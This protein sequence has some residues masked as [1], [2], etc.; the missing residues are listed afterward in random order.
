MSNKIKLAYFGTPIFSVEL[1]KKII[2]EGRDT[3]EV[4]CAITQPDK[5]VGRDQKITACPVKLF[6]LENSIA[7]F[8]KINDDV[9]E[10]LKSC[11]IALVF[12]F[13]HILNS[14]LLRA[15]K[16]GFWNVH[17]SA[18]P[19]YRGPSPIAFPMLLGDSESAISLIQ[20]DEKMDHG[21][22]IAQ[23]KTDIPLDI[24]HNELLTKMAQMSYYILFESVKKIATN[25]LV[26][27][28]QDEQKKSFTQLLS[29]ESG[30]ISYEVLV[31][32]LNNEILT[33]EEFPE[34]IK[35]FLEKNPTISWKAPRGKILLWNMYRSLSPW[36]GIWTEVMIDDV[37]KRLKIIEMSFNEGDPF[38]TQVQLE[39]KKPVS[40][41]SFKA[42]YPVL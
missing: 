14:D 19:A 18:L 15:P 28:V 1:L 6:A 40:F 21:A 34:I 22:I 20:M 36:P 42:A 2:D 23:E 9:E 35:K 32:L 13:G 39:G 25:S 4:V 30:Y 41:A 3:F 29:R 31:K 38:I 11:D 8:D 7:V 24:L 16:Y 12:A 27:T 33:I 5:P 26:S 10:A 37:K 17:P